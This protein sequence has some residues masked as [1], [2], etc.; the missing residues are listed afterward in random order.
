MLFVLH[1]GT[2][3]ART[4]GFSRNFD[5][6]FTCTELIILCSMSLDVAKEPS[7]IETGKRY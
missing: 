4:D 1:A 2:R 3:K 6:E 5:S 7:T